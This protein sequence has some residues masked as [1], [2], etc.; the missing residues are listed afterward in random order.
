MTA[1]AV[2]GGHRGT[3]F[4]GPLVASPWGAEGRGSKPACAGLDGS[5]EPAPLALAPGGRRPTQGGNVISTPAC[6][7]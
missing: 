3:G 5:E 6:S 2:I 1:E 4:A 7:G